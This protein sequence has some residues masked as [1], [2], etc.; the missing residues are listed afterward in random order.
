MS[1]RNERM[2]NEGN[3]ADCAGPPVPAK[4]EGPT[5]GAKTLEAMLP[6][7]YDELRLLAGGYLRN[8]RP[9]HT[10]QRTALVHEAYLR[11]APQR[12][13]AWENPAHLLAIFARLMRQ[14]LTN[15]AVA[16]TRAKRGG[17]DPT[18]L[19]LEFYDRHEVDV[20]E[21]DEALRELEA[22]DARQAQIVELRFF[23]GLTIEEIAKLLKIS[24]ATVKREWAVAKLWLRQAL[25]QANST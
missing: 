22:L 8:E 7:V 24:P 14:T 13:L 9:E 16:R 2:P 18:D 12:D 10:L 5:E 6:L 15:H 20:T 3:P 17:S 11:L 4:A 25:S 19:I 1:R 21:V 23:G